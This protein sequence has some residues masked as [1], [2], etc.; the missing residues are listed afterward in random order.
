MYLF[1]TP[2]TKLMFCDTF[3]INNYVDYPNA[4]SYIFENLYI[5]FFEK[6]LD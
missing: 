5:L 3:K 6:F 2:T 1:A 4:T